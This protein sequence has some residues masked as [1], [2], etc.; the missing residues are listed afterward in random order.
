MNVSDREHARAVAAK[1][2]T[3][4]LPQTPD[5][6]ALSAVTAGFRCWTPIHDWESGA[7]G[8]TALRRVMSVYGIAEPGADRL[9]LQAFVTDGEQV[10][11]EASIASRPGRPPVRTTFVLVLSSGLV[12]EVR[13]YLDPEVAG[14]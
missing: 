2:L 6:V 8:L 11:A 3:A 4:C 12:D 1:L 7:A 13:C 14:G 5:E 9:P 10:V